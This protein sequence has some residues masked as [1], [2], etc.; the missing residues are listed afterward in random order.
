MGERKGRWSPSRIR[1]YIRDIQAA[2]ET[3]EMEKEAKEMFTRLANLTL[4]IKENNK[5]VL[6]LPPAIDVNFKKSDYILAWMGRR[7]KEQF[8]RYLFPSAF[9]DKEGEWHDGLTLYLDDDT[10]KDEQI[11][12]LMF[13]ALPIKKDI[14]PFDAGKGR[15]ISFVPFFS[16]SFIRLGGHDYRST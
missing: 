9:V 13:P 5:L 8:R 7:D 3:R 16:V 6:P 12:L 15:G 11:A 14:E 2:G 4:L 1:E 10:L